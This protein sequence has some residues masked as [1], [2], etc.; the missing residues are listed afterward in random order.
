MWTGFALAAPAFVWAANRLYEMPFLPSRGVIIGFNVAAFLALLAAAA[1][2]L[3]LIEMIS[4]PRA[5]FRYGYGI[6][7]A[8]ALVTVIGL[9]AYL[10]G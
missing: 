6:L 10:M 5:E 8:S 1:G 3:K 9:V 4:R 2:A 7:A